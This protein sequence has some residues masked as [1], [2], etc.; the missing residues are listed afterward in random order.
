MAK[1]SAADNEVMTMYNKTNPIR[2]GD[3]ITVNGVPLTVVG[4]FSQGVFPDDVTIIAPEA[5]FR[6]VAGKQYYNMIGVQLDR[7]ISAEAGTYAV[8]GLAAGTALGLVLNRMLY[9]RLITHYFGAAWQVPWGCLAVI[10][11]VVSAAV[12]LAVHSP[13]RRILDLPVTAAISEL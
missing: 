3:I 11:A 10:A 1:T 9:T 6:R 8:S 7:M 5:L 4:A 2:I 12:V 13:V